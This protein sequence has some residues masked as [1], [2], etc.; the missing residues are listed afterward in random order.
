MFYA[1]D[2]TT[3][4]VRWSYD[5]K[6]DGAQ[7]SFHG[8]MLLAG[9]LVLVGTDDGEG[10]IYA[11]EQQS[12]AVRWKFRAGRGVASDIV[13]WG[14]NVYGVTLEDELVCLDLG[15]GRVRWRF[16][17]PDTPQERRGQLRTGAAVA[18]GLVFFAGQDGSLYGF[19]AEAGGV[20]WTLELGSP[21]ATAPRVAGNELYLG[22]E[23]G[24]LWRVDWTAGAILDQAR[25]GGRPHGL[26]LAPDATPLVFVDWMSPG[27]ELLALGRSPKDVRWRKKPPE[28][29]AWN[30]ARPAVWHGW[31][32]AGTELGEVRAFRLED[33]AERWACRLDGEVR[34]FGGL[35]ETLYVGTIKG[36][37]YA[38][39]PP[40]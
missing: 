37:L 10:H 15:D 16:R 38:L 4:A 2:K 14:A 40:R 24:S 20:V 11:F 28:P 34:V 13:K 1:L 12:G 35:D 32:L 8:N 29:G 39:R 19:E 23:D 25:P 36:T 5:I 7:T 27:G 18:G 30:T 31:V 33:G 21:A 17:P 6:K 22:T 26:V 3:G 9:G